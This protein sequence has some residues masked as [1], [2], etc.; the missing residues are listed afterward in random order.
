MT[1]I[2]DQQNHLDDLDVYFLK[3]TT[4]LEGIAIFCF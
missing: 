3:N 2:I 1:M 4:I